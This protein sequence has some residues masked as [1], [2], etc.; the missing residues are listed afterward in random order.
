M[1]LSSTTGEDS[2]SIA[3]DAIRFSKVI[4]SVQDGV[5]ERFR[6]LAVEKK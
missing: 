4:T 6:A 5:R 3:D 1:T 2:A